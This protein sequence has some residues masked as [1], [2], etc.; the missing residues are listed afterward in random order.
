MK[1]PH[2]MSGLKERHVHI[3]VGTAQRPSDGSDIFRVLAAG[4]LVALS[5]AVIRSI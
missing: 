1:P 4:V 2:R 3:I 5:E